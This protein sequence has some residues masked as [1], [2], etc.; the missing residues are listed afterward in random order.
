MANGTAEE[1]FKRQTP[2]AYK[3]AVGAGG[4]VV[5]ATT[6]ALAFK[7]ETAGYSLSGLVLFILLIFVVISLEMGTAKLEGSSPLAR[8]ARIQVT[9]LSWFATIAIMIGATAIIS[10][11]LI[12]W[13]LD[14][15]LNENTTTDSYRASIARYN[16]PSTFLERG[17]LGWEEKS[18]KDNSVKHNFSED[19][20]DPEFLYLSDAE[21]HMKMRIPTQGGMLEWSFNDKFNECDTKYCWGDVAEAMMIRGSSLSGIWTP[22]AMPKKEIEVAA[23]SQ[24]G[25]H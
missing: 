2:G 18:K 19:R 4:V 23:R 20:F 7:P 6:A 5:A 3:W 8:N 10:S 13:P 17:G 14:M 9:V 16:L 11:I 15:S 12:R 25:E 1:E 21:R 24:D 22:K